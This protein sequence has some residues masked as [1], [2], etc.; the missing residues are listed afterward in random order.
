MLQRGI[1]A[2]EM[3]KNQALR[4]RNRNIGFILPLSYNAVSQTSETSKLARLMRGKEA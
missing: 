4:M 3:V 1:T 2:W